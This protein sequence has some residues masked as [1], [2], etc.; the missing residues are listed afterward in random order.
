[1]DES[2]HYRNRHTRRYGHLARWLVGRPALLV[3]ATPIVNRL[4]DLAHQLWL[5]VR[6]D[7]LALD[8]IP[9]LRSLLAA[10][11]ASPALGRL[12]LESEVITES[13]PRKASRTSPPAP[14]E[15][16]S[17]GGAVERLGRLRLSSN[18][19]TAALVRGV[20]LRAAGSSPAAL[21]G[22]LRRYRR[23]LL[24]ARDALRSGRS[25]E[26]SELRRFTAELGDQ[27]VW[28]ELL[29]EN[30]AESDLDLA[31]LEELDTQLG[32]AVAATE[33]PDTKLDRLRH[34]LEDGKSS[35]VFTCSRDTVGYI[36]ER[37]SD[38]GLAWCTGDRAGIGA[39][40]LARGDVLSWFRE[41]TADHQRPRHLIVT[42]VAAE[43]LDL[44]R[45]GRVVHY[46]LPW[47]PMRLK[48]RE[49]RAVRLGSR[50]REVEV[51]RFT[52]PPAMEQSLRVEATL[53]RKAKL[54]ASAGLGSNGR[55]LWRW[56]ADLAGYFSG[57]DAGAGAAAVISDKP[58]IL[59][60][61]A[62]YLA[63]EPGNCL[64]AWVGWLSPGG[65]WSDSPELIA[66]RLLSV[67]EGRTVPIGDERLRSCLT[68]LI[69]PIRERMA[70]TRGRHW[71][72]RDPTPSARQL[73]L[74]LNDLI[75]QAARKRQSDR[76]YRLERALG[77]VAGGHTAGEAM[78]IERLAALD[79][80]E[81]ELSR[82]PAER[83]GWE[84]IEVRLT[85]LILFEDDLAGTQLVRAD[86]AL[87]DA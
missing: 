50:H 79:E 42:D 70:V 57:M 83:T 17:F 53:T 75:A 67:A 28:W 77:F 26:R 1:V 13:R 29:P 11:C 2:H 8:G 23:L 30:G 20:L 21:A 12:V 5:A 85:G 80:I 86:G 16:A 35:L 44:Q 65:T 81:S 73:A 37:L 22:T 10:G 31:D 84:G 49:G 72:G 27:L 74:R 43:G 34:L 52:P 38:L 36:R 24:H 9:S 6:D 33:Q 58:G 60:G 61:F 7:T 4:D 14:E 39:T 76:L 55:H 64:S 3:T 62:L 87:A 63:R 48:Q 40:T 32:T 47:T 54:P 56:R 45:A 78:L 19:S 69:D 41:D 25:L 82:L 15:C 71:L 68:L 59:A 18:Q 46:D 66:E 51:V